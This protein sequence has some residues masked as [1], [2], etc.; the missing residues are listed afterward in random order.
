MYDTIRLPYKSGGWKDGEKVRFVFLGEQLVSDL[1]VSKSVE[2]GVECD[3]SLH[4][5]GRYC[6]LS[7]SV[8]AYDFYI[9][10][11]DQSVEWSA[12]CS[13]DWVSLQI[14][15]NTG[16]TGNGKLSVSAG[17]NNTGALRKADIYIIDSN[18][19]SGIRK[20]SVVQDGTVSGNE[21]ELSDIVDTYGLNISTDA[22]EYSISDFYDIEN[23]S[24]TDR[25]KLKKGGS[26]VSLDFGNDGW[27]DANSQLLIVYGSKSFIEECVGEVTCFSNDFVGVLEIGTSVWKNEILDSKVCLKSDISDLLDGNMFYFIPRPSKF[28]KELF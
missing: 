18:Y 23:V 19:T 7:S 15:Y 17:I 2:L 20:V 22:S 6:S 10:V 14:T 27:E 12:K 5:S 3:S 4:C 16:T 28:N 11:G 21:I 24:G 9:T 8:S 13:E 26:Y 25:Y 1:S